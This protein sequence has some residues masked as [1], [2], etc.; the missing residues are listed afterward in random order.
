MTMTPGGAF[1]TR[2]NED[3]TEAVSRLFPDKNADRSQLTMM[4]RTPPH[5]IMSLVHMRMVEETVAFVQRRER[6]AK[7][8]MALAK[9]GDTSAL[10][11]LL[12]EQG[13]IDPEAENFDA[14]EL[15]EQFRRMVAGEDEFE[16][17]NLLKIFREEYDL[18]MISRNGEGRSELIEIFSTLSKGKDDDKDSS[19][20]TFG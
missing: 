8:A 5:M 9:T 15:R 2:A 11:S 4:T 17:L 14:D 1:Q 13:L 19:E 16:E 6:E 3:K 7:V 10:D 20:M 18:R 12:D